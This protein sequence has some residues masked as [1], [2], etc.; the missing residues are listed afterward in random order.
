VPVLRAAHA[1][2]VAHKGSDRKGKAHKSEQCEPVEEFDVDL[3]PEIED[4]NLDSMAIDKGECSQLNATSRL[5][6]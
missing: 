4:I 2:R 3:E 1:S 6:A 5:P